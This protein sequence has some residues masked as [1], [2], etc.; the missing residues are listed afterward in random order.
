MIVCQRSI[1]WGQFI[2]FLSTSSPQA[3]EKTL[4][5]ARETVIFFCRVNDSKVVSLCSSPDSVQK[6]VDYRFGKKPKIELRFRASI[7]NPEKKFHRGEVI[8]ASNS[9]D[10][11]WFKNGQFLYSLFMPTRGGPGLQVSRNNHVISRQECN[12]GWAE[13]SGRHATTS[14]FITEHGSGD[15]SKF[16]PLWEGQ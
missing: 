5:E 14:K 3:S 8:Y 6:Y 15:L 10:M 2:F 13:V 7:A 9:A 12:G 16:E 4:C 11:I 1:F